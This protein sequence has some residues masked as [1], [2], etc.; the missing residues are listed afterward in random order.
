METFHAALKHTL[1]PVCGRRSDVAVVAAGLWWWVELLPRW[2][3]ALTEL[4]RRLPGICGLEEE[5]C[6]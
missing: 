1:V 5:V 2:C 3:A 4:T 6:V